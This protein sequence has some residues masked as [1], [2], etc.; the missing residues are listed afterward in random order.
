ME[1][2]IGRPA[3]RIDIPDKIA[4]KAKYIGDIKFEGMLY[5]KTLRSGEVRA[6]ILSIEYPEL[7]EGYYIV[8]RND[9]PGRNR[10]KMVLYDQPFFAEG[11]VNYIGEPIALVV[12]PDK[13]VLLDILSKIHVEY[14]KMEPVYGIDDGLST[15]WPI[16]GDVNTFADCEIT[17]GNIEEIKGSA[18]HVLEGEYET[19]YQEQ[20]YLETQG[21]VGLYRDGKVTIYGSIQCPYYVKNA[22][23]ECLGFDAGRVQIVQVTTGGA[24]GGKEEY[25]S[26]IG[27]QAAC[28]ALKTKQPVQIIFDRD[29]DIEFTTKRHPSKIKLKSYLNDDL[30]ITGM[31]ADIK[32]DAGAY[33]GLSGVVLQRTVF[34]AIGAYNVENIVVRG[35]AIATNKVVSGAFRGFG[36]PQAFFA[37]EMHMEHIAHELRID[38]LNLKIKNLLKQGDKTSTGGLFRERIALPEMIDRIL[39]MSGYKE[40]KVLFEDERKKGRLKGIGLSVFFH[41]GG[42]T[43]KGERDLIKGEVKLVK[44]PDETVEILAANVEMGQGAQTGLRKIAAAALGIPLDRVIYKNP[45]TDR[46]PDSGPTVASRTTAV[47]GRL[48][49]DAAEDLKDRWNEGDTVEAVR[50]YKYPEGYTWD[51]NALSGDAYT[52]YSWGVNV[53]E[54]ETDPLTYESTI[55]GVWAVFD[56]GNAIDTRIVKGQID[57]GM[58]QGLGYGSMEVMENNQGRFSQRTCTDYIIPTSKDAPQIYS[59]LICQPSSNGPFGAKGLGELTLVGAPAAYT[60]AVQEAAQIKINKIPVRP[61]H[62]ME[63]AVNG[64]QH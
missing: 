56:I 49:K 5:A 53:V 58:L 19:G 23:M 8:D 11:V 43:G 2:D 37:L 36:G 16:Y 46:V 31:E 20:F 40:K 50:R 27:G 33:A 9:V 13:D 63:V 48:V 4:G 24:F 41:G 57:G 15:N 14:E 60:I 32:L 61:E 3:P 34:A 30:K 54:I 26:L 10:V 45:D 44:H 28:A 59:K 22:V 12:G 17:K 38:S 25:P 18:K 42:F 62:L 51:D 1:Y 7:P 39:N 6:R 55:N 35:K 52:S 64:K 47:V 29:E 21:V